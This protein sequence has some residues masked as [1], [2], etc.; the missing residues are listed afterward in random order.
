VSNLQARVAQAEEQLQE[1]GLTEEPRIERLT[2]YVR[3]EQSYFNGRDRCSRSLPAE[4]DE[5]E[6]TT[7]FPPPRWNSEKGC[8]TTMRVLYPLNDENSPG[9]YD[10][11][12]GDR[13]PCGIVSLG[14]VR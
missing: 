7:P 10:K 6:S 2:L 8:W 1:D 14:E 3:Y 4:Y 9:P 11:T 13:K 5:S 12:T